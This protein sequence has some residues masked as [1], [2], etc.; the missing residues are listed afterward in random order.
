M[1]WS[2]EPVAPWQDERWLSEMRRS[3]RPNQYLRMVENRFV[4]SESS[5]VEMSAWDA[6]VDPNLTPIFGDR[7]LPIYCAID[8]SVKHDST[9]IVV[10]H[11]CKKEQHVRLIWHRIYQPSPDRP[12]DFEATIERTVLDLHKRF[13]L[14]KV[15]FDPYQMQAMSQRLARAAVRVEEFPQTT[16]RLLEASQNLFEL[17]QGQ[18]LVVYRDPGLRLAMSHAVALETNRGWRITKEK[19]SHKVDVVIALAMAALAAVKG[20]NDS[21]YSLWSGWLEDDDREPPPPKYP[22]GMSEA[23]YRRIIASSL[24]NQG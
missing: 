5:F 1:F 13:N 9:A 22:P 18:N 3:L 7:A 8:A 23:E 19:H 6:C 21:T 16:V 4:S 14:R 2:H 17:V 11:W 12:L 15:L 10:V 24:M 20:Q